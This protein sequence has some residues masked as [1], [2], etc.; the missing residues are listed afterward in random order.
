M[1]VINNADTSKFAQQTTSR[2]QA[3][4]A[5]AAAIVREYDRSLAAD[6]ALINAI[7]DELLVLTP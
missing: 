4:R 7:V 6:K 3:A 1:S 5:L 2:A